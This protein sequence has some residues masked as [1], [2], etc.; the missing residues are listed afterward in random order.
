[1][2]LIT[3]SLRNINWN[4]GLFSYKEFIAGW[5]WRMFVLR[6][7]VKILKVRTILIYVG[8]NH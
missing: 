4:A 2:F 6:S 5:E 7:I 1:M 3:W 8:Q